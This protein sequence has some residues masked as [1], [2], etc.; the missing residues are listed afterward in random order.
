MEIYKER[1]QWKVYLG[2]L[3][4]IIVLIS[5]FYTNHLATKL[6][7]E[8]RKKTEIWLAA[9]EDLTAFD[10]EGLEYCDVTLHNRIL[11]SNTNTPVIVVDDR[12]Q[13]TDAL[14]FG[15]S[16]DTNRV[17]LQKELEKM[18]N[19][20]FEPIE[21]YASFIYY[22]ESTILR[23]LRYFPYAQL[24]LIGVFIFFGYLTLNA[25]RRSEQNRI[26][27]GMAKETAHQLGTPISA[28]VAWME[29]LKMLRP[30]DGEVLEVVTEL[31]KDM[32]RLDLV[33]D[34]FSKIG[35]EPK[36]EKI[37]M[38]EELDG[39]LN[40][41]KKRASKKVVFNLL[42]KSSGRKLAAINCHLFDWVV[43]NLIRNAL[44]AMGGKGEI[45]AAVAEEGNWINIDISDTGK[46][47]PA[48]KFKTVF[49]PGFT[50][51]KRGWG[52]GLSL[53]KRIIEEYHS[54]RIFVRE[55]AEGKGTTFRIQLPKVIV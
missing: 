40:Y 9:L 31:E 15:S 32:N 8:E 38:L 22:K 27:V 1:G 53:A 20:D 33:A 26:W 44:D 12:G 42:D 39:I 28:I 41:M 13:I 35:S 45:S 24:V 16:L 48:N 14:N 43:E 6:A 52:L 5:L 49:K 51:K 34:R 54:G 55:S 18:K 23:Q 30:N 50:T 17:F 25:A 47:I 2:L 19:E 21:G 36:L 10:E 37:D 7:E 29:H 4:A 46:G 3:G 11:R